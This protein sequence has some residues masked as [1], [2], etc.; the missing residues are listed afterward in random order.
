MNKITYA[1][2]RGELPDQSA[3][4][5]DQIS[6]QKAAQA[7]VSDGGGYCFVYGK[8]GHDRNWIEVGLY[9]MTDSAVIWRTP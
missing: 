5:A 1:I 3:T 9:L 4:F 2:G 6:A 8:S 7:R